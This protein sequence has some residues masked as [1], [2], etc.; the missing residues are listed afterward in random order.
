MGVLNLMMCKSTLHRAKYKRS[1]TC[2]VSN[3][4]L[5]KFISCADHTNNVDPNELLSQTIVDSFSL[6]LMLHLHSIHLSDAHL[7]I[8]LQVEEQ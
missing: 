3:I 4:I 2:L 6:V 7:R 1:Y 8:L 5:P